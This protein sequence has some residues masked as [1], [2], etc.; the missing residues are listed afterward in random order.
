[1]DTTRPPW[2]LAVAMSVFAR[3]PDPA[4][5]NATA[6]KTGVSSALQAVNT[7]VNSLLKG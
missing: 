7:Q 2:P 1:M 6:G 4:I 5:G 3:G